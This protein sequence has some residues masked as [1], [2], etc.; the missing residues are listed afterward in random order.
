MEAR[1]AEAEAVRLRRDAGTA[2]S[3]A[4]ER[5]RAADKVAAELDQLK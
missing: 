3:R 1:R 2:R 4:E 5:R